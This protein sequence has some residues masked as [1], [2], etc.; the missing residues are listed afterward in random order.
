MGKID[1]CIEADADVRRDQQILNERMQ[2]IADDLRLLMEEHQRLAHRALGVV[3]APGT[4]TSSF[5]FLPG[6]RGD[7]G[8]SG[9]G[10]GG[11]RT[12]AARHVPGG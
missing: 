12:P 9:S 6:E 3:E 10:A 5:S 2:L 11:Q 8:A 1:V 7:A 4:A